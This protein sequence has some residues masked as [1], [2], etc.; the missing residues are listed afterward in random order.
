MEC[1][2]TKNTINTLQKHISI[3]LIR[4][5]QYPE[6]QYYGPAVDAGY[7]NLAP[8]NAQ[9]FV[10]AAQA[11]NM[12]QAVWHQKM[13]EAQNYI[14]QPRQLMGLPRWLAHHVDTILP[15]SIWAR[16]LILFLLVIGN[17]LMF[18]FSKALYYYFECDDYRNNATPFCISTNKIKVYAGLHQHQ[19][20]IH[21]VDSVF[22]FVMNLIQK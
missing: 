22:G 16:L 13:I 9:T 15:S 11:A 6:V 4:G 21:T 20:L 17:Y 3:V 14:R 10:T 1:A 19:L 2:I 7:L 12:P 5:I 18:L 8:Y